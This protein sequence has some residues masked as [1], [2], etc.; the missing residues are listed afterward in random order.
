MLEQQS[1]VVR[2]SLSKSKQT[3]LIKS[4]VTLRQAQDDLKI[5]KKTNHINFL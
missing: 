5:F 2:L 3:I 1:L 4:I